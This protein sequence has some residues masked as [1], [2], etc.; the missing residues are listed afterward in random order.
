MLGFDTVKNAKLGPLKAALDD[1]KTLP[2][3]FHGIADSYQSTVLKRLQDVEFE[4]WTATAAWPRLRLVK[5]EIT[6]AA[7]EAADVHR[8]LSNAYHVFRGA[9]KTLLDTLDE[10]EGWNADHRRSAGSDVL[11]IDATGVVSLAIPSSDPQYDEYSR[12]YAEAI[13]G[14]NDRIR[15]AL[16]TATDADDALYWALSQDPNGDADPG[17]NP[18]AYNSIAGARKGRAAVLR[19]ARRFV[20]LTG[21]GHRV[22][23]EQ[24]TEL[25]ELTATHRNDPVFGQHVATA[26]GSKGTLEFWA[27]LADPQRPG[28][29]PDDSRMALLGTFQ[30]NLGTALA[31]ATRY[32]SPA[33]DTW[34]KE[35][36]RLGPRTLEADFAG[37]PSYFQVMSNLMRYGKYDNGFL[38]TY[39]HALLEHDQRRTSGSHSVWTSGANTSY[40]NF[41]DKNDRGRDPV[42]GFLAALGHN[43][44]AAAEFF[45]KPKDDDA[46]DHFDYLVE[47]RNW[48]PDP[49]EGGNPDKVQGHNYLGSALEAATTGHQSDPGHPD[50]LLDDH[51]DNRTRENADIMKR[52]VSAFGGDNDLMHRLPGIGDNLGRIGGAWIDELNR[53]LDDY[54]GATRIAEGNDEIDVPPSPF[55]KKFGNGVPLFSYEDSAQFLSTVGQ[56]KA[57]HE[58]LSAAQQIYTVSVLDAKAPPPGTP[59]PVSD[60]DLTDSLTAVRV[61]AQTHAILDHARMEQITQ[62]YAGDDEQQKKELGRLGEWGKWVVGAAVG[63]GVTVYS[64]GAAGAVAVPVAADT[65]GSVFTTFI[66]QQIDDGASK[67]EADSGDTVETLQRKILLEGHGA[68]TA[69]SISYWGDTEWTDEQR[70]ELHSKFL[71][72]MLDGRAAWNDA[73][74]NNPHEDE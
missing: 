73:P 42:N 32:D 15:R 54:G 22:S 37:K 57:G 1:W 38:N 12:G 5:Q 4:G 48:Q 24:L 44:D 67:H 70:K 16:R 23:D 45:R 53:G 58:A 49:A 17:F 21:E 40:L 65:V 34:E 31:A 52:V 2:G 59:G 6:A 18:N 35:I 27:E 19:D 47:E 26:L 41:T 28:T 20:E 46:L 11:K 7:D 10:V 36:V 62:D 30:R 39:G 14:W 3:K 64:G 33:M 72:E 13:A 43:P 69:A 60:M 51:V 68:T 63:T 74:I 66:G 29:R 50:A 61:G 71:G 9:Q 56:S 8:L 25:N 55:A